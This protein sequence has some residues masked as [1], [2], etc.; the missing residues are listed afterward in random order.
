MEFM[1]DGQKHMRLKFY[2]E[3]SEPGLRG[4]VHSESREVEFES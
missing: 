4:T 3:G 2:I 1:K